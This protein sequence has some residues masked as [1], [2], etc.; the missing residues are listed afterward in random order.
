MS[1]RRFH[2]RD[3][4]AQDLAQALS[5]YRGRSPVVLAVPRGAVPMARRV[6]DALGGELDVVLVRK[7]GA[8]GNPELAIGAVDE[9][10]HA[11]LN[12]GAWRVGANEGYI[13]QESERQQA[14][15]RERRRRYAGGRAPVDVA[16]RVAIVIDDGL[17]TGATMAAALRLVRERRPERLVCAVPVATVEGLRRAGDVADEVVCLSVPQP[18]VCVAAHYVEFPQVSDEEV[19]EAIADPGTRMPSVES[20]R[21]PAGS[22]E[23]PGELTVPAATRGLIVFVHGSGSSRLSPRNRQ[24]AAALNRAGFAT[25]LFD[26]LTGA[27]D[28]RRDARF[29]IARLTTRLEHALDWVA[30]RPALAALPLGLFGASTGSAVALRAA[31]SGRHEVAAVVS[32]GGRPDLAGEEMLERVHAPTL[33]IVGGRDTDVLA[34]NEAAGAHLAGARRIDVVAGAGHLFEEYGTLAQAADRA[35]G[36]FLQHLT[37]PAAQPREAAHVGVQSGTAAH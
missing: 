4:A 15:L 35:A 18:F 28:L 24:V 3:E 13:R 33:L 34:L 17:A 5:R 31:A 26:L 36:W 7:L 1:A 20:V 2:D 8:P 10:G 14:A 30:S 9:T 32:R 29:D 6:A 25:L 12:E 16:G 37:T 22:V 27:E 23:L 19:L 11:I 21:I